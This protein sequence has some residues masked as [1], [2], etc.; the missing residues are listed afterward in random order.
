M[1]RS[2]HVRRRF[3]HKRS[4]YR[5]NN[6]ANA[7]SLT[8]AAGASF[9]TPSVLDTVICSVGQL[10]TAGGG[11]V[12]QYRGLTIGGIRWHSN[13]QINV[14][15]LVAGVSA[16]AVV[17]E[18]LYVAQLASGG[19]P[20][21][22]GVPFLQVNEF[23]SVAGG[24]IAVVFPERILWRRSFFTS[25]GALN[26]F[27]GGPGSMFDNGHAQEVRAKA[28]LSDRDALVYRLEISNSTAT[29]VDFVY[30]ALAAIAV[31]YELD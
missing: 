9:G 6:F 25:I 18:G 16:Y 31:K 28:R 7:G 1:R 15:A 21:Q 13:V 30:E 29:A 4:P 5:V 20:A 3:S 27:P 11:A 23:S 8:A 10:V 14:T 26:V 24:G 22:A 19:A 12:N 17:S 2:T